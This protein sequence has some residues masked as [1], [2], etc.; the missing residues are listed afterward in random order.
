MS[1]T[2]LVT[3]YLQTSTQG[4]VSEASSAWKGL[5]SQVHANLACLR[6]VL[7]VFIIV[8]LNEEQGT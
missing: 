7:R 2:L 4:D 3:S 6:L 1:V 5:K 8:R